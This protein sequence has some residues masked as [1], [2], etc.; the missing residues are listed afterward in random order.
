M[1][2]ARRES[3][4]RLIA[5][6]L[7]VATML[8]AC[9]R[10]AQLPSDSD[11]GSQALASS[12]GHPV[13]AMRLAK[14]L[15]TM[16]IPSDNPQSV[17]KVALGHQL[18]FDQRLSVDGSR[19]CYSCHQ[20]EDGNGG[21]D[22]IAVG[23]AEKSVGIHSPVIW[24]VG[25]LQAYY[26]NGRAPTLEAQA[27][28]AWSGANMGVGRD[29]LE[30]KARE[31]GAI[32]AYRRQ[33]DAVFPG[34]GATPDTIVQAIAAY[35]RTLVCD[36]TAYDRWLH[37]DHEALTNREK[38]GLEVFLGKAGCSSC[39]APPHFSIA[40]SVPNG[41]YFNVGVGIEGKVEEEIDTGRFQ[42]TKKDEDWAAF[43]PPTLRNVSRSAPYF[44]DGSARTLE[45]AV[46]FMASGGHPN[47]NRSPLLTD[48]KLSNSEFR[49]LLSFL[50][51]LDC[52]KQLEEPELP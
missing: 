43:K 13:D 4:P 41:A 52:G 18:F 12:S 39:H 51:A 19:A 33:F 31:I 36:D 30:A 11:A 17:A 7:A 35:E 6:S 20:N 26:W 47:R 9:S 8:A 32:A 14:S 25:F 37:G 42:V 16:S 48:R 38:D 1:I 15:G 29:G 28:A 34:K 24:N 27:Q 23:A 2:L 46:R 5:A 40:Y 21:H 44:H 50:R 22:P 49:S 3:P 10:K 45:E